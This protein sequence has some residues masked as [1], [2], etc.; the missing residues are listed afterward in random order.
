MSASRPFAVFADGDPIADAAGGDRRRC[1]PRSRCCCPNDRAANAA[2]GR[3]GTRAAG[4]ARAAGPRGDEPARQGAAARRA[5]TRSSGSPPAC[6]HGCAVISATNGKTTTAGD[7]GR[8]TRAHGDAARPQPLGRQHGGGVAADAA[9]AS[10]ATSACSRSTSSGSTEL[11]RRAA[12]A[13]AAAGEPLPR[14]ARPLR[15]ARHDRRALGAG[16]R[17]AG[18]RA[19]GAE[20]RRPGDRGARRASATT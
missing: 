12:P 4:A 18:G 15:R 13:R 17:L 1:R 8:D 9:R 6:P 14:P 11:V 19:P 2:R 20:R 7:G 5:A 10:A 3:R 16:R